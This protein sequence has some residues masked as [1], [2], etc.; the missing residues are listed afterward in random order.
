MY[1]KLLVVTL[2]FSLVVSATPSADWPTGGAPPP[3][4]DDT[5][6]GSDPRPSHPVTLVDDGSSGTNPRPTWGDKL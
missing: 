6:S 2:A 5:S 3:V 1:W 4:E